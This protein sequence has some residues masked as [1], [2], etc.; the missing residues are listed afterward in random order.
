MA[1]VPGVSS[2]NYASLPSGMAFTGQTNIYADIPDVP[3]GVFTPPLA[4]GAT[5]YF[6]VTAVSSNGMESADS[7]PA[8][9]MVGPTAEVAG[10]VFAN[11][12]IGG[13]PTPVFL[14]NVLLTLVNQS[15]SALSNNVTSDIN[16]NF[17][18]PPMPSGQYNLCWQAAGF[19]S[20]C[21]N[22]ITLGVDGYYAGAIQL[23]PTG[24]SGMLYGQVEFQDGSPVY[25]VDGDFGINVQPVV[26]LR[27]NLV[28]VA[29][30]PVNSSGQYF[31]GN[32]PQAPNLQVGVTVE[33]DSVVSNV[34]TTAMQEADLILPDTPPQIQSVI[35]TTNG[36]EVY[37]APPGITVQVTVTA[38]GQNL[39]YEWFDTNGLTSLPN[40]P[41]ISWVIP[42]SAS[43]FQYLWVRVSDGNGG[44]AEERVELDVD[45]YVFIDGVV[46]A[47]TRPPR[48]PT[49][50]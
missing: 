46:W 34:N 26:I 21:S 17:S 35:A 31:M 18:F 23:F 10:R 13:S 44:Y 47:V 30:A 38:T 12:S 49:R 43:G 20:G 32:V 15:N 14:P 1:S 36:V 50:R 27:S 5:Y 6:V 7:N 41:V 28:Q 40:S 37:Q 4:I 48:W 33:N 25:D 24:G 42:A 9:G 3:D 8:S 16:G 45:P 2:Q 29:S 39:Q 11:L 19:T 22:G